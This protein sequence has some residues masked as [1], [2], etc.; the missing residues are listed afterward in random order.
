V[1]SIRCGATRRE[2]KGRPDA[3]RAARGHAGVLERLAAI[4]T[5]LDELVDILDE[6]AARLEAIERQLGGE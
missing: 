1:R 3:V 5:Q 4:E 2:P 6:A